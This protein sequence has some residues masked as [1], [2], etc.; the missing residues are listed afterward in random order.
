MTLPVDVAASVHQLAE[1]L[2]AVLREHMVREH[3]APEVSALWQA[4]KLLN[5]AVGALDA[6]DGDLSEADR[7]LARWWDVADA[8]AMVAHEALQAAGRDATVERAARWVENIDITAMGA[9]CNT[10]AGGA[11]VQLYPPDYE[12]TNVSVT[13]SI[14]GDPQRTVT[15]KADRGPA[16]AVLAHT[17]VS[18]L[19]VAHTLQQVGEALGDV[20]DTTGAPR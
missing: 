11:I 12:D 7:H 6:L 14:D 1:Q 13:A 4:A 16:P 17:P 9:A 2:H 20:V 8:A 19:R 3:P 15:V 5:T 18:L 10:V